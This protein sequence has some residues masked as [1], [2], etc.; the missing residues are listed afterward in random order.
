VVAGMEKMTAGDAINVL[1]TK[2]RDQA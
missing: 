2:W 1:A